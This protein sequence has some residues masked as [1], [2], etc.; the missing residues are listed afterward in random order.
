MESQP[1]DKVIW[2]RLYAKNLKFATLDLRNEEFKA[3]RHEENDLYIDKELLP[4]NIFH[5]ISNVHFTITKNLSDLESPA[6][7]TDN[8]RNGT[9][10][11]GIKIGK[12]NKVILKHKDVISLS[13][14]RFKAIVYRDEIMAQIVNELPKE[15]QQTYYVG[16]KLGSGA[17]GIVHLVYNARTCESFAMKHIQKNLLTECSKP[18]TN[19]PKRVMNEVNIMKTLQHPCIIKMHEI[20]NTPD[21]VYIILEYM[22][23]GD[24]LTRI[25]KNKLLPDKIAKIFFLQLCFAVKYLHDRGITHRDLKPDNI[26]LE[27]KDDITVLKVSDFGL[28]KFVQNNTLMRTQCGTAIYIAPEVLM[29]AGTVPYTHKVDIWSLG[30][31]LFTM[32]SGTIPF[33]DDYGTPAVQQ[34]KA[35]QFSF[36][37]KSWKSVSPAAKSL[38]R[39]ILTVDPKERPSMGEIL[40]STW[41]RDPEAIAQ[42]KQLMRA[43]TSNTS[44]ASTSDI[45]NA[46]HVFTEPPKKRPRN[47]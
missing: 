18:K 17:C 31:V 14:P 4:E 21:A 23:G 9:F 39:R 7:I 24:L 42:V 27:S 6:Y 38:I 1:M 41:L 30:V 44:K 3:G 46:D 22:K 28:S 19:D 33:S 40:G 25:M 8:S 26:L 32:L 36:R 29:T 10:V 13:H 16:R 12:G 35:G 2:G 45:E 37:H 5:G 20:I 34:I 43:S 11:N 15:I 47:K